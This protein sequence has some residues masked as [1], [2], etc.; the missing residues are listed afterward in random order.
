MRYAT[1]EAFFLILGTIATV[2]GKIENAIMRGNYI[3]LSREPDPNFIDHPGIPKPE[4][5]WFM[6]H[7]GQRVEAGTCYSNW[8]FGMQVG[9]SWVTIQSDE[10]CNLLGTY[11]P[12]WMV[13]GKK[14]PGF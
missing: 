6:F 14:R 12:G 13:L 9:P 7:D 1:F 5:F 2:D 11:T 10:H 8:E 4:C 3:D